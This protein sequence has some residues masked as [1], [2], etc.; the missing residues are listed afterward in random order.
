MRAVELFEKYPEALE[1]LEY[2][3][4]R[5]GLEYADN[6]RVCNPGIPEEFEAYKKAQRRGCCGVFEWSL[7]IRGKKI[8]IG[9]NYGH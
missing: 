1:E 8:L 3:I 9:C 4:A 7:S 6:Y 2:Q 5:F